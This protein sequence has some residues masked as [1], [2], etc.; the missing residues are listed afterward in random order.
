MRILAPICLFAYNRLSETKQTIES[1]KS[2]FLA[3]ES[4][5]FIF[6]DG[7]KNTHALLKVKEVRD[8]LR[9]VGGFKRV[10]IKESP[11]N[12]GLAK[13]I[14]DGVSELL[15]LYEN[16][17]VLE[18]DLKTTSNFLEFMN[19]SLSFYKNNKSIQSVSGYSLKII[20]KLSSSD[21]YFHQRAHSWSWATWS[22]RWSEDIFDKQK[23]KNELTKDALDSFKDNC[24][25]DISEM[26]L[27]SINGINDSWYVRWAY[28]HF[29]NE[30][31][32]VYPYLSKVQNI[33]FSEQGTH[34]NGIDVNLIE[35]DTLHETKFQF[36]KAATIN[37]NIKKEFLIYFTRSYK[38]KFRLKL[39]KSFKG[40]KKIFLEIRN[41]FKNK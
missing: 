36:T 14:I 9:T 13:S 21:I 20:N 39:L 4:E 16:I 23:L 10:I 34:C 27:N 32:A 40:Q 24:G 28:D 41:K 35:L 11:T 5:L 19:Q 38:L 2:N 37:N 31:Y 22:D 29:K 3:S 7:P 15:K 18:D 25:D 26:L 12:K 33:G 8:Y 1:L 17:I 6:S 30:K